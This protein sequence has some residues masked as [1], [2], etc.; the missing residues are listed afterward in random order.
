[1]LIEN[2]RDRE[3]GLLKGYT[4]NYIPVMAKGRDELMNKLVN[5]RITDIL[6]KMVMSEIVESLPVN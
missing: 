4:D 6:D 3:T 1:M 5:V 2:T